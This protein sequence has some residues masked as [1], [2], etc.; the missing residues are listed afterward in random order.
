LQPLQFRGINVTA[1]YS[2]LLQASF[3]VIGHIQWS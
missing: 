1:Y 3:A 2:F